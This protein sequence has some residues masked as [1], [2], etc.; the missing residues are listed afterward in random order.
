[1]CKERERDGT[2][3]REK[4]TRGEGR[5]G[6]KKNKKSEKDRKK[7]RTKERKREC[8][9]VNSLGMLVPTQQS[10]STSYNVTISTSYLTR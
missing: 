1:M 9:T 4:Q 10:Q 6:V 7:A 2:R 5:E 8:I 3:E